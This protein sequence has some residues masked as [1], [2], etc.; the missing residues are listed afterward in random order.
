MFIG[1]IKVNFWLV[2]SLSLLVQPKWNPHVG[3]IPPLA[4]AWDAQERGHGDPAGPRGWPLYRAVRTGWSACLVPRPWPKG[5][6]ATFFLGLWSLEQWFFW[7]WYSLG[8]ELCFEAILF[9]PFEFFD[10]FAYSN[11]CALRPTGTFEGF[12]MAQRRSD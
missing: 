2:T 4:A 6:D 5:C 9:M 12:L 11:I 1:E 7:C 8:C 10:V 3:E